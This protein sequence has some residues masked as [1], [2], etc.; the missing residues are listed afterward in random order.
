M[1]KTQCGVWNLCQMFQKKIQDTSPPPRT[2]G[3]R[4]DLGHAVLS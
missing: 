3:F 1:G 4:L 2:C